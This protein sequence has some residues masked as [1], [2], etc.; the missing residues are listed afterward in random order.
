MIYG[1]YVVSTWMV[2]TKFYE[3]QKRHNSIIVYSHSWNVVVATLV[4]SD[5]YLVG[6]QRNS[7]IPNLK[8]LCQK[9]KHVIFIHI[10]SCKG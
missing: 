2:G 7:S 1:F 4:K 9:F 5:R 10:M 6:D 3:S 8:N